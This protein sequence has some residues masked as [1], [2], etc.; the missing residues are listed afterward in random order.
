MSGI[1]RHLGV[2]LSLVASTFVA[3]GAFALEPTGSAVKVT[4]ITVAQGPGGGRTLETEGLVYAGDGITTDAN[5]LAQIEFVDHTRI[6]VGPN[7]SLTLDSFVFNP[8]KTAS[9]VVV[10]AAR[11]IFRFISGDSPHDAYSIKLPAM[12]IG[13]RGTA[14]DAYAAPT[15]YVLFH[16]GSGEG[17]NGQCVQLDGGCHMYRS[18]PGGVATPGRL[19]TQRAMF[20]YFGSLV[21]NQNRLE[22]PFRVS[23]RGCVQPDHRLFG[24]PMDNRSSRGTELHRPDLYDNFLLP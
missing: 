24:P 17:C 21:N 18:V 3:G 15:S 14:F 12:V 10:S 4:K 1:K 20:A 16:E 7:A 19:D 13:V 9:K 2:V 5:G 23:T 8:D 22:P 6:V 11:G